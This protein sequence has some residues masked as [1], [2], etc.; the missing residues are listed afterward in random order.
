MKNYAL[1][2][3]LLMF[4]VSCTSSGPKPPPDDLLTN[5]DEKMIWLR[6]KEEQKALSHSGL[7][8]QDEA[9]NAYLNQIA[10]KLQGEHFPADLS[11]QIYVVQ[12][13]YLN[14]FALP[15][16]AIY[17]HTG[18]L[19]RMNNE[20]QLAAL[21]AHEIAHCVHRHAL[22][23]Y[24]SLKDKSAFMASVKITLSK[25]AMAHGLAGSLGVTGSM[26]AVSGY[27]RELETEADITGLDALVKAGYDC[28]EAL[29]LFEHMKQALLEEGIREPYFF[30]SHP[31][32]AERIDNI[33]N[34]LRTKYVQTGGGVKNTEIF[35][36]KI[37]GAILENA[38]LDLRIGRFDIAQKGI[39][40]YLDIA[41]KDACGHYL[42][43]EI[44]RQRGRGDDLYEALA[45]FKKAIAID[46][47]YSDPHKA[48]GLIHYKDG[49]K[50][51]ARK[52]FES[53][54]RLA[55]DAP[56]KAYI[57]GYIQQCVKD[58]DG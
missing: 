43:G 11:I 21:L 34:L 45:C 17:V 2:L 48:I 27:S 32:V 58:G 19:A 57:Q 49:Q 41:K 6:S 44:H 42:M 39:S 47:S 35:L 24:R 13:P 10:K 36:S 26:A 7:L 55:P 51:L 8:Y 50:A 54:L 5:A 4:S 22:I 46:P 28:S 37:K 3:F 25:L 23:V 31:K 33:K 29:N 53:C 1:V 52:F 9:L 18:I 56:D 15:H 12:D 38:R 40:K 14:A 16:G 30:G 20:A